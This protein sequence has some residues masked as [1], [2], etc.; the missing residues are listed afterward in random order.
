MSLSKKIFFA[1]GLGFILGSLFNYLNLFEQKIFLDFIEIPGSLFISSLKMLIVPVVFF[2][3]VCGVSNLTNIATLGRI[4]SISVL[5]YLTTTCIAITL[6]LIFSNIIDPGVKKDI[7]D[8]GS[9]IKK[10]TPELKNV[11]IDIIPSNIFKAFT[12]ANML[13]VIFLLFFLELL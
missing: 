3:I 13:Q 7:T 10:E 2:S 1:L 11:I 6:A 4:G 8:I 12:E 9:I 5:L